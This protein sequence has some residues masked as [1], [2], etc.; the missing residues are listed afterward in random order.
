MSFNKLILNINLIFTELNSKEIR[1]SFLEF[2]KDKDHKIVPSSSVVPFNDPTLLFT[3]AGMNQFKDVFLGTGSREYSRAADTQKCIRAGGKHNDLEEVGMDGYHHTFFEMLGNWSFGD[4]Y[5]KEAIKWAWEL[6][7]DVWKL[8]KDKLW[9][10][11]FETDE[12]AFSIWADETDINNSHILR[13][14]EKDNFWEMGDTG[15]CGPCSEIHF[16][17]TEKGC[18]AEDV[19]SGHEEVIEI[20]NLVFIQYNRKKDGE[21]EP[22][23]KK[24]VDTGMGFE[25]IVRVLQNKRSNYET[26]IFTPVI[27][28]IT[29]ITGKNYSGDNISSI[30]AIADHIRSL[31]FAISD[32]AIPSNEGRGYVLR[33]IL[34]RASRLARKLD[35]KEPVLFQLVDTITDNFGS[36]FPELKEKQDLCKKV[37]RAEEESFHVTLD[38]G[39]KLFNDVADTLKETKIFPGSE[40]FKLYD[41]FGFPLDL[42]EV[43]AKERGLKVD[44]LKFGEE[45]DKQKERGKSGR[46]DHTEEAV[47]AVKKYSDFETEYDPYNITENG[48]ET[49]SLIPDND[50]KDVSK[51]IL[52][53][54][55]NPFYSESG[56]QI[57][58][59]GSLV[60]SNGQKINVLDSKKDFIVVENIPSDLASN[61]KVTAKIDFE[62]RKAI[63][64]N[65]SATHIV[66]EALK[67]VLGSHVKQLGSL[68]GDEYLRFDFPHFSKPEN[69]QL[70]EIEEMVNSKIAENLDVITH[71]DIPVEEANKIPNVKKFFGDKYGEKVRVVVIDEN[72][73]AEFCGGTHTANTKDIGLFKITKEES[74]ASGTRRIFARTGVGIIHFLGEKISDLEKIISELPDKYAGSFRTGITNLRK[75]ISNSDFL[76]TEK[77]RILLK[78]QN[79]T[80]SELNDLREKYSEEKKAAEK[81]L[82]KQNLKKLSEKLD[83]LILNADKESGF[84]ILPVRI[85]MESMDEFK[86]SGEELRKKLK[87][88]VG[89]IASV[90]NDKINIVCSVSDNLI[91]EKGLNAGKII[92]AVAKELG[93]GGGGKPHLASA[94]AKDIS[95]LDRVLKEFPDLIKSLIKQNI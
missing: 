5:K 77:M 88:G 92:S 9:V 83:K 47:Q 82:L 24:H 46:K 87:N 63:Q 53:L 90:M 26:D 34:R 31:V 29:D 59:T 1:N 84:D 25:R 75:D 94:G 76:N 78:Y 73:S 10:T 62:R 13:F 20:W 68:V 8:P 42:T 64:R 17:F 58:D 79:K 22:L 50:N 52:I 6:L 66:H 21:L 33:R 37:I 91:K 57:S 80:F 95:S 19:N 86:E 49:I 85:D 16:D 35:Y 41:T 7:T 69:A 11:V 38:R 55:S 23:P 12:E 67:R 56:G 39:I 14:G 18:K 30:N 15:P 51:K 61:E 45:M 28:K 60:R 43:M 40:A 89:L 93:G 71:I 54:S 27:S 48:K 72:F 44:L 74:I 36:V 81:E 4:Y 70:N 65:H 32:G 2:F 3:N